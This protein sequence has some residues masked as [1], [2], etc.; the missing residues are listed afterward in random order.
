LSEN[1]IACPSNGQARNGA[2][3]ALIIVLY[4]QYRFY[5]GTFFWIKTISPGY[6]VFFI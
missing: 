1:F 2:V 6:S 4:Y 5:Y 3:F